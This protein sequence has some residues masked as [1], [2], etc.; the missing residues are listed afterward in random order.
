[1]IR[2]V[3]RIAP[4]ALLV[5][6]MAATAVAG[7]PGNDMNQLGEFIRSMNAVQGMKQRYADGDATA[8]AIRGKYGIPARVP[9]VAP[10]GGNEVVVVAYNSE[11]T[12][13][14]Y[15]KDAIVFG[16][17]KYKHLQSLSNMISVSVLFSEE[18]FIVNGGTYAYRVDPGSA[19]TLFYYDATGA[20]RS[21]S[22]KEGECV[23]VPGTQAI[24]KG[25][26][27]K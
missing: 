16:Q 18:P 21:V 9:V 25:V 7:D 14:A 27:A 13:P 15:N 12:I 1:M 4:T 24:L 17:E 8:E 6:A 3:S 2:M 5:V 22:V 26:R 23:F 19:F 11:G 10:H 20:I